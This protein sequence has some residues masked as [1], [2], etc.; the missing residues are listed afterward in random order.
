MG[1]REKHKGK[2]FVSF[3]TQARIPINEMLVMNQHMVRKSMY[4]A[5]ESAN[6]IQ[7]T[8]AAWT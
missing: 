4:K 8:S 2:N 1:E 5:A 7:V 3:S 6:R